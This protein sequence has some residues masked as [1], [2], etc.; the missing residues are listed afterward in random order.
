MEIRLYSSTLGSRLDMVE[1]DLTDILDRL[2]LVETEA[3]SI[4]NFWDSPAYGSW[5]GELGERL[6]KVNA[7]V[8]KMNR[9]LKAMGEIAVMLAETERNNDRAVEQLP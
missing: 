8:K 9:L 6:R 4:R 2:E 5:C 7:S 3:E 1:K